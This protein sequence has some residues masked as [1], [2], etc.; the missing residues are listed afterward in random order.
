M[1]HIWDEIK[2]LPEGL[3]TKIGEGGEK[4]SVGQRQRLCLARA[5]LKKASLLILDEATSALDSESERAINEAIEQLD[6]TVIAIAHRSTAVEAM[7]R[8]IVLERGRVVG[9]N[10]PKVLAQ[11]HETYKRIF[12]SVL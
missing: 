11:E 3:H 12:A 10:T 1:A 4:L 7:S 2:V 6:I 5:F 9:D 8:V